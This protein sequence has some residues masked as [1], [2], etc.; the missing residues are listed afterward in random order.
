MDAIDH[1][2]IDELR[3]DG[4][5]ANTELADRVGL[6]P[7]PCLRRVRRLEQ[8]GVITG[9]HAAVDPAATGTGFEVILTVTLATHDITS[10]TG[11]EA[12]IAA[13]PEVV[14][15][16]RM[17]GK[18]DYFLRVAV[19]DALAYEAFLTSSLMSAPAL[20]SF[21]SHLTMKV[22]GPHRP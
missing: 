16:R 18:P 14:E 5:L 21:D 20:A 22:L 8:T 2:I 7:S 15:V 1:A 13:M 10:I 19:T 17:F 6:T 12:A 11:F 3:R 9:Y 4:R